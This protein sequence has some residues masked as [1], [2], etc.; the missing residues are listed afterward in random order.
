MS[1]PTSFVKSSE[2]AIAH[3]R[4]IVGDSPHVLTDIYQDEINIA[5]WQ[6]S[7]G[8]ELERAAAHLLLSKPRLQVSMTLTPQDT[9]SAIQDFLGDIHGASALSK[10]ISQLV[11]M[12]CCLFDLKRVGVRLTALDRAMCPR[13]HVDRVPCRLVTTYRGI[14]TE[15][16]PHHL[17]DRSKLGIG[18]Q[19]KPDA[20]SGLFK[21]THDIQQLVS[22]DVALLK[23]ELWQSNEGAGLVHRSPGL[24]N[25]TSRLLMT[26][27]FIGD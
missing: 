11:D 22:G 24:G 12:F 25:N 3:R 5:I 15:W 4:D 9:Y 6:R 14:A 1:E 20:E 17:V 26:V 18:N 21:H 7:L 16:L 19:G 2:T 8:Q 10:D 13:F 23:G 27:D